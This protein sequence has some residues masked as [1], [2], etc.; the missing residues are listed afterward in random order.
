MLDERHAIMTALRDHLASEMTSFR[1]VEDKPFNSNE[2]HEGQWP[3]ISIYEG[4]HRVIRE[5]TSTTDIVLDVFLRM[6]H[7]GDDDFILGRTAM[8][9]MISAIEGNPQ[10]DDQCISCLAIDG[11]PPILWPPKN[12]IHI[13]DQLIEIRYRRDK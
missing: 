12:G 3:A 13:R 1:R 5:L 2:I 8:D 11:D 4:G 9:E 7:K 6:F 10:L